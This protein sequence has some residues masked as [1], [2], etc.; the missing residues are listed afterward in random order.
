M[1]ASFF[2]NR[3]SFILVV[4]I[5]LISLPLTA[6]KLGNKSS[7]GDED[8]QNQGSPQ[9][10]GSTNNGNGSSSV[11][12]DPNNPKAVD[13]FTGQEI[14]IQ[15][16][17]DRYE[18]Y[19][20]HTG[21]VIET[22]DRSGDY[23]VYNKNGS[24]LHVATGSGD[25]SS[26]EATKADVDFGSPI[27]SASIGK[28]GADDKVFVGTQSNL[29]ILQLPVTGMTSRQKIEALG[30]VSFV[31]SNPDGTLLLV[32][33]KGDL[34]HS[35][36]N[37]CFYRLYDSES[38][39]DTNPKINHNFVAYKA[40]KSGDTVSFLTR[41]R[42]AFN[43]NI[44]QLVDIVLNRKFYHYKTKAH[45]VNL[46]SKSKGDIKLEDRFDP[47][48]LAVKDDKLFVAGNRYEQTYLDQF[49]Q[50]LNGSSCSVSDTLSKFMKM[51]L[52]SDAGILTHDVKTDL[53]SQA[54]VSNWI[55]PDNYGPF[56]S[57]NSGF[58][59][60]P[61]VALEN[62]NLYLRGLY[63]AA[64][65]DLGNNIWTYRYGFYTVPGQA[66]KVPFAMPS[67]V[68]VKSDLIRTVDFASIHDYKFPTG[69]LAGHAKS[70]LLPKPFL[71]HE[72]G[73]E[74]NNSKLDVFHSKKRY[75]IADPDD[76][77]K[78]DMGGNVYLGGVYLKG[79]DLSQDKYLT[80]SRSGATVAFNGFHTLRDGTVGGL[81]VPDRTSSG[82]LGG[83]SFPLF[84][85]LRL[86]N[87][88]SHDETY[89]FI[90][91]SSSGAYAIAQGKYDP[92]NPSADTGG[93]LPSEQ[94]MVTDPAR[95]KGLP[96]VS[97]PPVIKENQYIFYIYKLD[98][99]NQ[100]MMDRVVLPRKSG[101]GVVLGAGMPP[102]P[103]ASVDFKTINLH[104]FGA[105][106]TGADENNIYALGMD[107]VL[108]VV[109]VA[110]GNETPINVFNF[111]LGEK[112]FPLPLQVFVKE[113]KVYVN[114]F[115]MAKDSG[116]KI[117]N[118]GF[119]AAEVDLQTKQSRVMSGAQYLWMHVGQY[120]YGTSMLNQNGIE[121]FKR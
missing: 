85:E 51:Y 18:K 107:G 39:K 116:G 28:I 26:A 6:C 100:L 91:Y 15:K 89:I 10:G 56:T 48:D 2:R 70:D 60:S 22:Y 35:N 33:F 29:Q 98:P 21:G 62:T 17:Y 11:S 7:G 20:N 118:L 88:L 13:F 38:D 105:L 115:Y 108:H 1:T 93:F 94:A 84:S 120:F 112:I 14:Q 77:N 74:E 117:I 53:T 24:T 104:L 106:A 4:F 86:S 16:P 30:G 103:P 57:I 68:F 80:L 78:F 46:A 40:V 76:W 52:Y 67:R 8:P 69:A 101:G 110:S 41:N 113:G 65:L 121:I 63:G 45:F 79:V 34:Y 95:L 54:P 82:P 87:A 81:I 58:F 109:D 66:S 9:S 96:L 47:S 99:S 55:A 32:N 12:C 64:S 59:Y 36:L 90:N 119:G 97:F 114:G 111:S 31:Q 83:I 75:N 44:S 73:R 27:Y 25:L 19:I 49:N 5:F 92:L 71:I 3:K 37:G 50:C 42:D 23:V 43:T 72:V 102:A 61:R